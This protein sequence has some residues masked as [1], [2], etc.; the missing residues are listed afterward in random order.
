MGD[1][2]WCLYP[3]CRFHLSEPEPGWRLKI[4][5]TKLTRKEMKK[6]FDISKTR[7]YETCQAQRCIRRQTH[8]KVSESQVPECPVSPV[9]APS[10]IQSPPAPCSGPRI[11][12]PEFAWLHHS[13][14][15]PHIRQPLSLPISLWVPFTW[16]KE[17]VTVP[18]ADF[19]SGG[20]MR[21]KAG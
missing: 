5:W 9:V 19:G 15:D 2:V 18:Y 10:L 17:V 1:L 11:G 13:S 12:H 6:G 4:A 16:N 14:C 7:Y 3:T 8:I 21:L 20:W